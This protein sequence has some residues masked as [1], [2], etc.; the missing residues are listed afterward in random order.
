[1]ETD[2]TRMCALLVGLP[3][4]TVTGVGNDEGAPLRVYVETVAE[5]V[6]C[7]GCGTRA[8][9]KDQ[10]PV[11]LVDLPAFGRPAVLVWLK[12]RWRCPER[13]CDVGT[14]TEQRNLSIAGCRGSMRIGWLVC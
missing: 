7:A 3:A 11:E 13:S 5:M 9:L 12:R 6:G 2:A 4:I 10:R 14:W 1:M 8:W